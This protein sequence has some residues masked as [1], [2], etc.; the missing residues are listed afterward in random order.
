MDWLSSQKSFLNEPAHFEHFEGELQIV[1]RR[2]PEAAAVR[3]LNQFLSFIRGDRKWLLQVN[4]TTSL[5]ALGGKR[6]MALRRRRDV[7]DIWICRSATS[8]TRQ[9]NIRGRRNVLRAAGP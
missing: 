6:E 3:Q 9:K 4:M 2:N 8:P 1:A 7:N 5:E